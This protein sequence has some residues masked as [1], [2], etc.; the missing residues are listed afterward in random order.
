[1][2]A[3]KVP[4]GH[5]LALDPNAEAAAAKH[6]AFIFPP[7]ESPPYFGFPVLTAT[8]V[9]GFTYGLITDFEREAT[10]LGRAVLEGD[11]FVVAPDGS[12]GGLIWVVSGDS[13]FGQASPADDKR[14]GVWN[15][16]FPYAMRTV[17]DA[18]RNLEAVLPKLRLEWER[19]RA[20]RR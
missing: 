17:E 7:L 5:P 20:E 4:T 16:S 19:W 14:W 9:E 2:A 1:M 11:G 8:C 15:V 18:R 12:R 3:K 6:P 10:E 13:Y